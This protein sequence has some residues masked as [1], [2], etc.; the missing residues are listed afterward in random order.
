MV[1]ALDVGDSNTG[2][3]GAAA[4]AVGDDND[5][6]VVDNGIAVV[7][8]VVCVRCPRKCVKDKNPQKHKTTPNASS[9]DQVTP[10]KILV[11]TIQ[12]MRRKQFKLE[13]CNTDSEVKT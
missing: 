4:D 12:N 8:V 5:K 3:G 9:A 1:F 6:D 13:C 2:G 11:A 10:K 7:V